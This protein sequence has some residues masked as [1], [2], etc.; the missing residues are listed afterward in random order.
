V[1]LSFENITKTRSDK[2]SS[3]TQEDVRVIGSKGN[4]VVNPST[5]DEKYKI[6]K[7]KTIYLN[8]APYKLSEVTIQE[9]SEYEM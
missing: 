4:S 1:Q 3:S 5:T 9:E 2:C 6:T 7:L 8:K